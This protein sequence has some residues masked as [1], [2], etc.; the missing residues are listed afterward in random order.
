[1]GGCAPGVKW[2]PTALHD[3]ECDCLGRIGQRWLFMGFY[4]P[5][6]WTKLET[7]FTSA[8]LWAVIVATGATVGAAV[9]WFRGT[10]F[11][12]EITS[13]KGE[14]AGKVAGLEGEKSILEQRLKLAAD[15]TAASDRAKDETE[16]Q[17]QTYK[18]EVV[19]KGGN[20]S[21]AKLEAAILQWGTANNA[22]SNTLTISPYTI[23]DVE[24]ADYFLENLFEKPENRSMEE[25]FR[26]A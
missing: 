12:R 11:G 17:F 2:S 3:R 23:D 18:T 7:A 8:P 9:W 25:V 14:M 16:K 21:P 1:V 5:D 15:L 4:N 24:E 19:A 6:D 20:A 13:L 10:M 26:F 22:V